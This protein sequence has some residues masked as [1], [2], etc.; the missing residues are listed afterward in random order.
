MPETEGKR[1]GFAC[2]LMPET[3]GKRHGFDPWGGEAPLEEGMATHSRILAWRIPWTEE[4]GGLQSMGSQKVGYDW[5]GTHIL[6]ER[7]NWETRPV[8]FPL[9]GC[10]KA[11]GFCFPASLRLSHRSKMKDLSSWTTHSALIASLLTLLSHTQGMFFKWCVGWEGCSF[12]YFFLHL[13]SVLWVIFVLLR[14][15]IWYDTFSL[16]FNKKK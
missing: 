2:L 7:W 15:G 9:L 12:S 1:H 8:S 5:A 16:R 10:H 6:S 14:R 3:E 4:P 11:A 13:S